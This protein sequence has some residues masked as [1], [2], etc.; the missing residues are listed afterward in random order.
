MILTTMKHT[1]LIFTTVKCYV[2]AWA[3]LVQKLRCPIDDYPE[4]LFEYDG[5]GVTWSIYSLLATKRS[6]RNTL[7]LQLSLFWL[8]RAVYV[9]TSIPSFTYSLL[10][11]LTQFVQELT[12]MHK[13]PASRQEHF[14]IST[15]SLYVQCR[16]VISRTSSGADCAL[17]EWRV[18]HHR[19][20]TSYD[21][22]V[23][24]ALSLGRGSWTCSLKAC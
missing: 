2:G 3:E 13:N 10:F 15:H 7:H 24:S 16:W 23:Q 6:S 21:Q 22:L 12:Y 9:S 4:N 14:L 19:K 11:W 5:N 17:S 1:F 8:H 18:H 20:L